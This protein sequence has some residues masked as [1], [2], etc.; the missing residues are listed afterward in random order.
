ML[1]WQQLIRYVQGVF[2]CRLLLGLCVVKIIRETRKSNK[3][4]FPNPEEKEKKQKIL[5][6]NL[7]PAFDFLYSV[8]SKILIKLQRLSFFSEGGRWKPQAKLYN[9][10]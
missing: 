10:P 9:Y 7:F 1:L 4:Q 3:K 8:G 6:L 2:Y 5:K